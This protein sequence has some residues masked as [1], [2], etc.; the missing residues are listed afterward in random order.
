MDKKTYTAHSEVGR[1]QKLFLK[2]PEEAFINQERIAEQWKDLNYLDEPSL[3]NASEEYQAFLSILQN[4]EIDIHF[5]KKNDNVGMDSMYCRDAS[6]MTNRGII[7][8]N[9]G[10]SQRRTEP[11]AQQ[12]DYSI[13]SIPILGMIK[14]SGTLEGGDVAWIDEHT[15]A[16]AHG[17][18]TNQE[19]FNQLKNLLEPHEIN[20]IQVHL[21]HHKGVNDVFHLMSIFSPIDHNLAVIYSPLMSVK[22]R[23]ELLQR[24]YQFVE[25]SDEEYETMGCNVLAIA[26]RECFSN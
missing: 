20:L 10:K 13:A 18:R 4:N 24:G 23:N 22:F 26:P 9:M 17:Y 5:F 15:L 16:V 3:V 12:D 2:K 21:P 25:V 8:C 1:I 6:I 19:G 7:L 14:G 11:A